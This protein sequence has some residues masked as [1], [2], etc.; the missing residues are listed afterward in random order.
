MIEGWY[1]GEYLILFDQAEAASA[2]DR[3]A[4]SQLLPGYKVIGLRRYFCPTKGQEQKAQLQR[5]TNNAEHAV[6]FCTSTYTLRILQLFENSVL[7]IGLALVWAMV[8][9]VYKIFWPLLCVVTF[10]CPQCMHRFGNDNECSSCS[11]PRNPHGSESTSLV[12]ETRRR[13]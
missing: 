3:Y 11:F 2:S 13:G 8:V 9:A 12:V 7:L 4:V 10:K 1:G 5:D 6:V